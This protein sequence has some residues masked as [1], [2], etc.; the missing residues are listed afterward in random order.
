MGDEVLT[1]EEPQG[2][3]ELHQLDEEIVFGIEARR[4]HRALEVERQPL[5]DPVHARPLGEIEEERDIEHDLFIQ[6]MKL[7]NT[8]RYAKGDELIT[9]LGA[10]YYD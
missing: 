10:E 5:L 1:L 6:L 8:L 7:K 2:V 9:H 3:L 4:V